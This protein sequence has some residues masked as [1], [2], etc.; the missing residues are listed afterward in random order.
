MLRS[1]LVFCS[2]LRKLFSKFDTH[3]FVWRF[4]V[5]ASE[6]DAVA[7]VIASAVASVALNGLKASILAFIL[8]AA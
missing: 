3:S 1:S 4:C 8:L 2:C 6:N 5:C 7:Y